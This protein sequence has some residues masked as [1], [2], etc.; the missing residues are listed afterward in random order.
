MLTF[1]LAKKLFDGPAA[2]LAALLT[3]GSDQLWK[4]SVSGLS[5]M[6]L[7]VIFLGLVLC[8][9]KFEELTRDTT[10]KAVRLLVLVAVAG[11]LTGLGMLTRYSFGWLIVP[12]VAYLIIFGG[13][14]KL[15]L[16]ATGADRDDTVSLD[17]PVAGS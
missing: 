16:V 14:R 13:S 2:W 11:L 6:L 3:I 8:L 9:V 7:L 15:A 12:V 4:F 5:T 17:D 1:V 10:T